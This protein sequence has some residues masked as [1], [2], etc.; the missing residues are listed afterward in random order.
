MRL[1][2]LLKITVILLSIFGLIMIYSA[3]YIWAEYKFG[4]PYKY[5]LNQS[6]FFCIGLFIMNILSKIDYKLYYKHANKILLLCLILLILVL[7]PGI[8]SIRNGSRSWFSLMGFGFQPSELSKIGLI[9][10]TSKYLSKNEKLMNKFFEG[11]L[12]IIILIMHLIE[13]KN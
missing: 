7:I 12:P 4:N 3:S 2:K 9:I 10:F 1:N 6:L 5:L 13:W 11:V 8:G